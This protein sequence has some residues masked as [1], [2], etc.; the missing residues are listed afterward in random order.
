[1]HKQSYNTKF[2]TFKNSSYIESFDTIDKGPYFVF[3]ISGGDAWL[4]GSYMLVLWLSS[5]H[6]DLL[7][8][9]QP[10]QDIHAD[11]SVGFGQ[12]LPGN[13]QYNKGL[14]LWLSFPLI[15][16]GELLLHP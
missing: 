8:E 9:F 5:I 10:D 16:M 7:V 15:C 2:K 11:E 6:T 12:Y 14:S 4:K 13:R 3:D 1:M